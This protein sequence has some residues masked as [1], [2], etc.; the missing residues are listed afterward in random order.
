[1]R[2]FPLRRIL[3]MVLALV[4]FGRLWCV[5]HPAQPEE[6][7]PGTVPVVPVSPGKP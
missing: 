6:A 4:A 7:P 1:M 2:P 5:T 3:L